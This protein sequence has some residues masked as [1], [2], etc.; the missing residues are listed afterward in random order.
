MSGAHHPTPGLD[1]IQQQ[2]SVARDEHDA[3]ARAGAIRAMAAG[4]AAVPA[5]AGTLV[6]AG[7]RGALQRIA[8]QLRRAGAT[9]PLSVTLDAPTIESSMARGLSL[10]LCLVEVEM[11]TIRLQGMRINTPGAVAPVPPPGA[12]DLI[13][14]FG[15][16]ELYAGL[17]TGADGTPL[18]HLILLP[19]D[20]SGVT[21]EEA[22][23]FASNAGGVLPQRAEQA[24]LYGNAKEEFEATWYWSS[25]QHASD[26]ERAW[27]QQF[28]NG[29]QDSDSK[30][31]LLRARAVRREECK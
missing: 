16:G 23:A 12:L 15:P 30:S 29:F 9:L 17:M 25:E 24:I 1:H 27:G 31:V 3:A 28:A 13:E 26:C 2:L 20:A 8:D 4:E 18:H 11:E 10:A 7:A 19:G 6:T 5:N 21:Y 22:M 14:D